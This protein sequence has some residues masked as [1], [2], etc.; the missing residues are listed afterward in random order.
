MRSFRYFLFSVIGFCVTAVALRLILPVPN[1]D[2]VSAKVQFI[3]R[4]REIDTLF[5][6]SSRVYHSVN[7]GVSD[8]MTQA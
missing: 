5:I 3:D 7:P 4:H 1:V 2:P 8:A 6:G